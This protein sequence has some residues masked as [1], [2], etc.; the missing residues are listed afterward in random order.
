VKQIMSTT[1]SASSP[2]TRFPN[3]PAASSAAP[4]YLDLLDLRPRLVVDVGSADAAGQVDHLVAGPDQPRNPS[5]A[6]NGVPLGLAIGQHP[7][8]FDAGWISARQPFR[9]GV[10]R[11]LVAGKGSRAT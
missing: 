1:T 7:S 4:V 10:R 6:A 3:V 11:S 2:A 8:D 5:S 9:P